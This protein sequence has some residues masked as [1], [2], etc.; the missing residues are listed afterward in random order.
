[1]LLP[2][3]FKNTISKAF[4]DKTINVLERNEATETDGGRGDVVTTVKSGFRGNVRFMMFG[5]VLDEQGLK[6]EADAVITC[7]TNTEIEL[8]D[9]VSY[10]NVNYFVKAVLP[11]DSH[12]KVLVDR[13]Q[14]YRLQE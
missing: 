9:V 8:E 3:G 5:E 14:V 10:K 1:M 11:F 6:Y 12:L 13:W 4:Y 2:D 7:P